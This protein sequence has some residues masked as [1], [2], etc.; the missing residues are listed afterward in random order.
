MAALLEQEKRAPEPAGAARAGTFSETAPAPRKKK[1]NRKKVIRRVVALILIAA[2]VAGFFVWRKMHPKESGAAELLTEMVSRG[3]ITSVV[4]G[5]GAAVAKNSASI[6]LLSNGMVREVLVSEGDYVHEGDRLY[7]IES[8]N[9]VNAVTTAEKRLRAA[10]KELSKLAEAANDLNVRADYA[11]ILIGVR[12]CPV[13]EQV[14]ANTTV[15]TLVDNTK[16]LLTLCLL[17]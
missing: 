16:L 11:G 12:D 4:K 9:A 17:E 7:T 6:T 3:S 2:L 5:S 13:G 14:P 15:A 1:K 8:E 10:K